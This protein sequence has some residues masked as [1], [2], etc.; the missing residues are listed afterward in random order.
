MVWV[1]KY[2]KRNIEKCFN[3]SVFRKERFIISLT[4][5]VVCMW[6]FTVVV[7]SYIICHQY[8]WRYFTMKLHHQWGHVPKKGPCLC[9]GHKCCS[10]HAVLWSAVCGCDFYKPYGLAGCSASVHKSYGDRTAVKRTTLFDQIKTVICT[11]LYVTSNH[12]K[13]LVQNTHRQ[14]EEPAI[15]NHLSEHASIG[16]LM[17]CSE[18]LLSLWSSWLCGGAHWDLSTVNTEGH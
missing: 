13:P 10:R 2:E 7:V 16:N 5:F 11:I 12:T 15:P 4:V 8:S 6:L 17:N 3:L 18:C 14:E 9:L 1:R